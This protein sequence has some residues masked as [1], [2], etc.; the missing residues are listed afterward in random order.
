MVKHYSYQPK[1]RTMCGQGWTSDNLPTQ[2]QAQTTCKSCLRWLAYY[3]EK[4]ARKI[5]A[6][7]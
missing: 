7:R 3:A 1:S 6:R 4:K 2:D 5:G